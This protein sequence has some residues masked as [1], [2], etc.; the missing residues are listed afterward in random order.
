MHRERIGKG[1]LLYAAGACLAIPSLAL[2]QL[3]TS[4]L[5]SALLAGS[6]ETFSSFI[7][8]A[9]TIFSHSI[10]LKKSF[11]MFHSACIAST[12]SRISGK[13][14]S[15][16]EFIE[17]SMM[18]QCLVGPARSSFSNSSVNI[19]VYFSRRWRGMM[20]ISITMR[21]NKAVSITCW[22]LMILP[23]VSVL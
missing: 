13:C 12:S 11:N 21:W 15:H 5:K 8:S 3:E 20:T 2:T 10:H 14:N 23:K 1:L 16:K 22:P 7:L 9:S 17:R 4:S 18:L 19:E 6:H